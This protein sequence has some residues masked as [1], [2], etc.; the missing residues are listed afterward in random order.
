MK[1]GGG[2]ILPLDQDWHLRLS[3]KKNVEAKARKALSAVEAREAIK[4]ATRPRPRRISS[5]GWADP[6][7]KLFTLDQVASHFQVDEMTIRRAEKRGELV[8]EPCGKNGKILRFSRA[9]IDAYKSLLA[10]KRYG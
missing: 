6:S 8:A 9:A 4:L 7:E 5:V 1:K 3:T 10:S 2:Q